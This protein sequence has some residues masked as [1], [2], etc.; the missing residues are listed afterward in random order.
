MGHC[1][2]GYLAATYL[3]EEL[4]EGDYVI[5][6]VC[7][8]GGGMSPEV[9]R[10]MFDPFF[11]TKERGHGLGLAATLGIIRGH[12]GAVSVYSEVGRGTTIK[13]L[14]PEAPG[15][16]AEGA[17]RPVSSP[18]PQAPSQKRCV[19]V[20]DDEETVRDLATQV[21]T[22]AA[23]E[24]LTAPDGLAAL[25]L[26]RTRAQHIDL[27]LLDLTMPRMSG[28]ETFQALRAMDPK[29]RVVLS[30]GYNQHDA[31]SRFGGKGLIGFLQ[32][33]YRARDLLDLVAS[34]FKPVSG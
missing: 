21:L 18:M 33:P 23:Y 12:K 2:A 25:E 17:E 29:V 7:D 1:D 28:E 5:M 24:V 31:S 15:A 20:V 13:V 27:V 8:S 9:K 30:S 3:H 32:K 11:S 16:Y 22:S 6:E 26:Y 19:L 4:P 14:I 34:A 10:R